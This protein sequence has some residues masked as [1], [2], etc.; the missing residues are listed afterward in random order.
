MI[1]SH[2]I[3]LHFSPHFYYYVV[4]LLQ[5]VMLLLKG[6][7]YPI[8]IYTIIDQLNLINNDILTNY[9]FY[10]FIIYIFDYI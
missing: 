10:N 2:I 7:F 4:E 8:I 9:Y 3:S 6:Q 1:L 5:L